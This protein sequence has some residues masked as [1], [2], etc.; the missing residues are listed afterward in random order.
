MNT[1]VVGIPTLNRY[2]CLLRCV[3]NLLSGSVI[4]QTIYIVDNGK[5]LKESQEWEQLSL[6]AKIVSIEVIKPQRNMGVAASWN[7]LHRLTRPEMLILVNDDV[8]VGH[9]VMEVLASAPEGISTALGW[10]CFRHDYQAWDVLGDYDE[11]FYPAYWEDTDMDWRRVNSSV[12]RHDY[13]G[14]TDPIE[15]SGSST[16]A[17]MSAAEKDQFHHRNS[18]LTEYYLAKWGGFPKGHAGIGYGEHF[19]KPFNGKPASEVEEI[20]QK[21][22]HCPENMIFPR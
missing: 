10:S 7:L 3:G 11:M 13:E 8:Y 19:T 14:K 15:H 9:N 6:H 4:P 21:F 17:A 16:I 20:V 18:I 5:K 12:P 1:F 2:D 22:R